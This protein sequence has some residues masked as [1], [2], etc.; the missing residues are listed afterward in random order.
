MSTKT[1]IWIFVSVGSIVG[2]Y[3]PALWGD[4]VFSYASLIGSGIGGILGI[5]IAIKIGDS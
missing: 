2:G 5:F 1:L 3:I 4:S